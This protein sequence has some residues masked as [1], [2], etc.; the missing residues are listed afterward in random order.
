MKKI[1]ILLILIATIV[2]AGCT[3]QSE[4]PT[5]A[6][7][8]ASSN[9]PVV[10]ET[11]DGIQRVEVVSPVSIHDDYNLYWAWHNET[12]SILEDKIGED[13]KLYA[14]SIQYK[15]KLVRVTDFYAVVEDNVAGEIYIDIGSINAI[16][17]EVG[18]QVA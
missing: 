12:K 10:V 2:V 14:F 16:G 5:N 17:G 13:V 18:N 7:S 15:G 3:E 8:E 11:T 4:G 9:E 1:L 6:V